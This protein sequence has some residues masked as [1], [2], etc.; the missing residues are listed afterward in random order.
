M[1]SNRSFSAKRRLVLIIPFLVGVAVGFVLSCV[2][3]PRPEKLVFPHEVYIYDPVEK[4]WNIRIALP[5]EKEVFLVTDN[6]GN[7]FEWYL[8]P[9]DQAIWVKMS[10]AVS[11]KTLIFLYWAG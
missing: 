8:D 3:V 11:E 1:R 9:D 10:E 7:P 4:D 6:V 5:P 2:I